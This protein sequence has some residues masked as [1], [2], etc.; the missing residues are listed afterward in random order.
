MRITE[1]FVIVVL[2]ASLVFLH[3]TFD[4][5]LATTYLFISVLILAMLSLDN[6]PSMRIESKKDRIRSLL[7][8]VGG[9][10]AYY[11][12]TA[13]VLSSLDYIQGF[14]LL[15][16]IDIFAQTQPLLKGNIIAKLY[17]LVIIA[18][19]AETYA[20]TLALEYFKDK[21]NTGL[22]SQALFKVKTWIILMLLGA[23]SVFLHLSAKGVGIDATPALISV[24]IFF[25]INMAVAVIEKQAMGAI[26]MHMIANMTAFL[27]IFGSPFSF[28]NPLLIG[29]IIIISAFVILN[30][31]IPQ[32]TRG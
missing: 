24:F 8:G 6:V 15:S 31:F 13:I 10:G 14:N 4:Q 27:F 12:I 21:Y 9:F 16:V 20:L 19:I 23:F 32:I 7:L 3:Q 25:T 30:N 28:Q 2:L 5:T 1:R 26:I 29:L 11:I 17:S 22:G 18:T